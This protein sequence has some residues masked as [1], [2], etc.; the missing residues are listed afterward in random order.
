M[1]ESAFTQ[2]DSSIHRLDPRFRVL[3]AL[4][5]SVLIS[6][7]H[8]VEALG[9]AFATALLLAGLARLQ[10]KAVLRRLL[11]LAGF[12]LMIACL[13][14]ITLPGPGIALPLGLTASHAGILLTR[15]I[16]LKSL[17]LVLLFMALV[18]TMDMATLG[19]TLLSLGLPGKLVQLLL[20]TYRYLSVLEQEYQRL[21]TAA[22]V[23]G[24]RPAIRLH[25]YQ[26][27]AYLMGMLLV[28]AAER[29]ERVHQA[30]R[31]RG[32][33]GR[34]RMLAEFPPLVTRFRSALFIACMPAVL[35]FL[36]YGIKGV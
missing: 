5:Y 19:H 30:M 24:F 23:R 17:T 10:P 11:P 7:M 20:M 2:P 27:Y 34:Y 28:R 31:C 4:V 36:E 1:I 12:L 21:R 14:P 8:Q 33:D 32:F 29:A 26:T 3:A 18:S 22:R 9:A 6:G 15:N 13:L 25:V 16:L 35:I